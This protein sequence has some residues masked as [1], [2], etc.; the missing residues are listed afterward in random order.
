MPDPAGAWV[1]LLIPGI[2]AFAGKEDDALRIPP[3]HHVVHGLREI[4]ERVGAIG[5]SKGSQ[6]SLSLEPEQP[7]EPDGNSSD[8][9][10]IAVRLPDRIEVLSTGVS[11]INGSIAISGFGSDLEFPDTLGAPSADADSITFPY[12][13]AD[14]LWSI[15]GN[16]SDAAQFTGESRVL[17][18][19]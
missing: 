10:G 18:T 5:M 14:A 3:G 7:P 11:H 4:S 17:A 12:N 9:N 19:A 16:L 13:P 6:W 8:A 2:S 15:N 1:A